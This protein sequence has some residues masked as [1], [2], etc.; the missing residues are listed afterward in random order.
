[1][2]CH[3]HVA[4]HYPFNLSTVE[5]V[6][7]N[8]LRP[9][10]DMEKGN[11]SNFISF[12]RWLNQSS[13]APV[14]AFFDTDAFLRLGVVEAFFMQTDNFVDGNNFLLFRPLGSEVWT[15]FTHDYD[16]VFGLPNFDPR[17]SR[18][19][20]QYLL[21]Y[22]LNPSFDD[23]NPARVRSA[24][25]NQAKIATY[26]RLFLTA[27]FSSSSSSPTL[28]EVYSFFASMVYPTISVD[29]L[30]Q[31]A[32]NLTSASFNST[33]ADTVTRL[34]QRFKEVSSQRFIIRH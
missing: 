23:Y 15:V 13:S 31:F 29:L 11:V 12:V 26:T 14:D 4:L 2:R 18:D 7:N 1:M 9:Y 32:F 17:V 22:K 20:Y 8:N 5:H 6:F 3:W 25:N 27:L 30:Q 21:K 19:I 24:L 10:Y 28:P 33:T 16:S 34:G